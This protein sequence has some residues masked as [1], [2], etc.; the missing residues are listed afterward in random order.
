MLTNGVGLLR[1]MLDEWRRLLER[2][3]PRTGEDAAREVAWLTGRLAAPALERMADAWQASPAGGRVSW[4][5]TT[6]TSATRS[7]SLGLLSGA[8]LMRALRALPP[9]SKTWCC[10]AAPFGFDGQ[11]TLD[12]VSAEKSARR[13]RAA[14]TSRRR[15]GLLEVLASAEA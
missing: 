5:S 1:S 2:R 11:R 7:A 14:C 8:D 4:W 9:A 12:G 13:T 10:R 3:R 15:R 6:P